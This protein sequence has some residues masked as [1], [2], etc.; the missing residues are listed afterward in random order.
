MDEDVAL[1][2]LQPAGFLIRVLEYRSAQ[3]HLGAVGLGRGHL[4]ERSC[5]RHDDHG[6]HAESLRVEGDALRVVAGAGG[7]YA[8]APL[9]LRHQRQ[10]VRCATLLERTGAL[11]ALQLEVDG[12][13]AE[14]AEGPR[15]RARSDLDVAADALAGGEDVLERDHWRGSVA[16]DGERIKRLVTALS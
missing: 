12:R 2:A 9:L 7:H 16:E 10:L 4:D 5:L 8:A 14:V 1:L 3:D 11:Q 15:A 6:L 13:A